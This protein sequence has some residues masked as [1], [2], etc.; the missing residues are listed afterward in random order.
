MLKPANALRKKCSSSHFS[1]QRAWVSPHRR[2]LDYQS[3]FEDTVLA[4]GPCSR[5]RKFTIA[6]A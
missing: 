6:I 3:A 2:P 4:A 5:G 1:E